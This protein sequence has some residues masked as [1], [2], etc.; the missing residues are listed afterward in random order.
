MFSHHIKPIHI[1]RLINVFFIGAINYQKYII[2]KACVQAPQFNFRQ[3][4]SCGIVRVSNKD[5]ACLSRDRGEH[6]VYINGE[7]SFRRGSKVCAHC[8]PIDGIHSKAM[9]AI[10][11]F[12]AWPRIG[13]T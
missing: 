4:G 1:V 10:E 6:V 3:V 13:P 11:N 2:P 9:G 8:Q 12:I 7:L 5:Q